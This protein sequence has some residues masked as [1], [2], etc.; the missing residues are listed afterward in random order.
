MMRGDQGFGYDAL[1]YPGPE[2]E[3]SA[4][5]MDVAEKAKNSHR[6]NAVQVFAG[7]IEQALATGTF[8]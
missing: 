4:A 5:Q 7:A 3:R 6:G 2:F 1:F 8:V